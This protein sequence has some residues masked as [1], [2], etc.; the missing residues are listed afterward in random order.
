MR[1]PR[2]LLFILSAL[3]WTLITTFGAPSAS[4]AQSP[5]T[6]TLQVS[7]ACA[8]E[9]CVTTLTA[10]VISSGNAVHS[11]LVVFCD[12]GPLNC[13]NEAP[14]GR[15]QITANGTA[16]VRLALSGG[17]HS[18]RAIFHGTKTYSGSQ[19]A[20]QSLPVT[21]SLAERTVNNFGVSPTPKYGGYFFNTS[22]V[23][24]YSPLLATGT[25][26]YVDTSRNNAI[27][28]S[29]PLIP[30]NPAQTPYFNYNDSNFKLNPFDL[31]KISPA[32]L[33]SA[34]H[35]VAGDFNNDG[36][37][38]VALIDANTLLSVLLGDGKGGFTQAPVAK[39]TTGAHGALLVADFN[40]DGKLDIAIPDSATKQIHVMLGNGD[41]T[42]TAASPTSLSDSPQTI[43][44]GDF[45][46][47]G[48]PD[49]VALSNTSPSGNS[50]HPM[51]GQG[52]GTFLPQSPITISNDSIGALAVSDFN[53]DGI[54]D[55]VFNDSTTQYLQVLKGNPDGTFSQS[56]VAS[57]PSGI[58]DSGP[59]L[60]A[61]DFDGD[62]IPDILAF[63]SILH[64][65][66]DF[67]FTGTVGGVP[68]SSYPTGF[69]GDLE[70]DGDLS[71]ANL[72][73]QGGY[74]SVADPLA[75]G[76]NYPA[77]VSNFLQ[78]IPYVFAVADFNRDGI[79]DILE[80]NY[81]AEVSPSSSFAG[82]VE[83]LTTT[84][85]VK[86]IFFDP[87]YHSITANYSGDA[88]HDPSVSAPTSVYSSGV[89]FFNGFPNNAAIAFNGSASLQNNAIQ[90][91]SAGTFQ[92][93]SIFTP[94]RIDLSGQAK[95]IFDFQFPAGTADGFAFV[96]QAN[97]PN[98]IGSPAG[99]LGYGNPPGASGPSIT[100][101][102]ALAFD[103]HDNQGEGSN[104][105]R[106]EYNGVTSPDGAVDLTPSGID[107]HSG[108][109]FQVTVLTAP[110][111][112]NS[113]F[114][115]FITDT[116]TKITFTHSFVLT[117]STL[118]P[119]N[120]GY[121]GFT[122]GTGGGTSAPTIYDWTT[123]VDFFYGPTSQPLTPYY[124]NGFTGAT[125]LIF[126]G[127]SS[128]SGSTLQLTNGTI[129]E[130]TSTYASRRV[131]ALNANINTDFDFS[132]GDGSGDGFTFVL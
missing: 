110:G 15:A 107:L 121:I 17:P 78:G 103:L 117:T 89:T 132:M 5:T 7:P 130:A 25:I 60:A 100:N 65:G 63:G 70:G 47:D 31:S 101:S 38:D 48:I 74:F 72:I 12:K 105:I 120:L 98:A 66:G 22:Y 108:H 64:G 24:A 111:N 88:Y 23:E 49:L 14:I 35:A 79:P 20:A 27:L 40:A 19:S 46:A 52:D 85:S 10:T 123:E 39:G 57:I 62:G 90:L 80:L 1:L 42:F 55:L 92:A 127:G 30:A 128:I 109:R 126:N 125:G 91:T 115:V 34:V 118:L 124:S 26:T 71:F 114:D 99:G 96:Y 8:Q 16:I 58:G 97:G 76:Y 94:S 106:I 50:I 29:T 83:T 44:L 53:R 21:P 122:A 131:Q 81:V 45:N 61:G 69:V 86:T 93:G 116:Q 75:A 11:G 102:V 28:T 59:Y 41:G 82:G 67:T 87:G 36:F 84:N 33:A 9:G 18:L 56:P 43:T 113:I 51:F 119:G 32:L 13:E 112:G 68:Y 54:Q 3:F 73:Q 129:F 95:T 2:V 4:H 77:D 37:Q 6:T 104:S